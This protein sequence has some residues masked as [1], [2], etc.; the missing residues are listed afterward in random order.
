MGFGRDETETDDTNWLPPSNAALLAHDSAQKEVDDIC[1]TTSTASTS[2]GSS[3]AEDSDDEVPEVE[4]QLLAA[5]EQHLDEMNQAS[6]AVNEAQGKLNECSMR[7]RDV[8]KK[9]AADC[10]SLARAVGMDLVARA[11]PYVQQQQQCKA[12]RERV[13]Q[14][15]SEFHEL[16]AASQHKERRRVYE[17]RSNYYAAPAQSADLGRAEAKIAASLDEY[18]AAERLLR[19][20]ELRCGITHKLLQSTLPFFEAR[21]DFQA[22]LEEVKRNS[23]E[24][25]ESLEVAKKRYGRA[26]QSLEALSKEEHRQRGNAADM[27]ALLSV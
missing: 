20:E 24:L 6:D 10:V 22:K 18:R 16:L 19:E 4:P 27:D 25:S 3:R 23:E 2:A 8:E 7:R 14:N 15:C 26:L 9:W 11:M 5:V 21:A 13:E 17:K 12:L 1:R